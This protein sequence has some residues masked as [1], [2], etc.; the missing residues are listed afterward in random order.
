MVL[1]DQLV[2][3]TGPNMAGK[4]TWMRQ[5]AL[6]VMLAQVGAFVPAAEARI[7]LVDTIY[8]R[9]G[10]VDDLARGRSTF[11]VEMLETAA[12]LEGATD[13]SLVILDEIGR[14]TSTH[15][16]MAIAWAVIERL[17][18][19]P[20]R[21]RAIL[22]THFHELAILGER[23]RQITCFAGNG[24]G[25]FGG[26]PSPSNRTR[27]RRP[28]LRYRSRSPCGYAGR[29]SAPSTADRSRDGAGGAR[30]HSLSGEPLVNGSISPI[31]PVSLRSLRQHAS[32]YRWCPS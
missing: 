16:G 11:M 3:L 27:R 19:G 12:V 31:V 21:P 10:A 30:V 9:I 7:D 5:V 25:G 4:S 1:S 14:G 6:I 28:Q 20:V 17:A 8:T 22:S 32:R 29:R 2:I 23:F 13:H 24:F 15:D 18:S 26:S